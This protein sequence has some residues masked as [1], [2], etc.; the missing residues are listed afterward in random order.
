[1]RVQRSR[2]TKAQKDR[3]KEK[4]Y[5]KRHEFQQLREL[6]NSLTEEEKQSEAYCGVVA[7]VC[8]RIERKR[9]ENIKY[10][11][12]KIAYAKRK[13][14]TLLKQKQQEAYVG[15]NKL[16]DAELDNYH[17]DIFDRFSVFDF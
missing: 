6:V 3:S 10:R 14:E 1:M 8:E 17:F 13:R 16:G 2:L 15:N 7:L 12:S 9:L 4:I 11:D 5:Q